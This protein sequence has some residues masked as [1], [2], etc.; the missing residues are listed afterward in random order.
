[1]RD[2]RNASNI[3][4]ENSA[5]TGRP[6]TPPRLVKLGGL[7]DVTLGSSPGITDSGGQGQPVG[8]G[9]GGVES[10]PNVGSDSYSP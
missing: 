7:R 1:M 2:K 10:I 8:G 6:Y 3:V 4:C 9:G 5:D